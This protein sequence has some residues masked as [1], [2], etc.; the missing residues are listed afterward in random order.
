MLWPRGLPLCQCTESSS[1]EPKASAASSLWPSC[2]ALVAVLLFEHE[3]TFSPVEYL[4]LPLPFWLLEANPQHL[5]WKQ[6]KHKVVWS[7]AYFVGDTLKMYSKWHKKWLKMTYSAPIE[8]HT[9]YELIFLLLWKGEVSHRLAVIN[10]KVSAVAESVWAAAP[11]LWHSTLA[12]SLLHTLATGMIHWG[13]TSARRALR[14]EEAHPVCFM[15][16]FL[17]RIISQSTFS[18]FITSFVTVLCPQAI[19]HQYNSL[20]FLSCWT[21]L[22]TAVQCVGSLFPTKFLLSAEGNELT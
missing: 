22:C 12:P 1:C 5:E 19:Y 7:R 8:R 2:A 20:Q 4:L 15:L 17:L 3:L 21:F 11:S 14:C 10:T 18:A 6:S 9:L 13:L 16:I